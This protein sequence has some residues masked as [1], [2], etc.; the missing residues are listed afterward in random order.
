MSKP[1]F[2]QIIERASAYV[3]VRSHWTRY[4]LALTRNNRDCEPT[5]AK[6]A[7]FCAY[8]ALVRAAY[9]LT[10]DAHQARRLAGQVAMRITGRDSPEEAYEEIYTT[11]DG[12]PK[13]SREAILNLFDKSLAQA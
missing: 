13:S 10:G 2:T 6:A 5:D 1:I 8:G 11:N 4:T 7:R 12:A 9:D 3:A